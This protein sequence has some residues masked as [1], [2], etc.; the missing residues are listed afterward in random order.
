MTPISA[1]GLELWSMSSDIFFDN[2]FVTSDRNVAE[3]WAA[4]GWGLKKAA[5]GAAEVWNIYIYLL[6]LSFSQA[7]ISEMRAY[8][9]RKK[10]LPHPVHF[11]CRKS[12][13][14]LS[15]AALWLANFVSWRF[16]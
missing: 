4:D 15:Q 7:L 8:G 1:V 3:R 9:Y 11:A 13:V 5:E 14:T 16:L 10:A 6:N 2:F 12:A